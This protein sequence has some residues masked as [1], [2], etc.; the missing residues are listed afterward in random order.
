MMIVSNDL[1]HVQIKKQEIWIFEII[2]MFFCQIVKTLV[3]SKNGLVVST[4]V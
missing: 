4:I 2:T 3:I 1:V